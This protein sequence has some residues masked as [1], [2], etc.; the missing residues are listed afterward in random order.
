MN[1]KCKTFCFL[2]LFIFFY[3]KVFSRVFFKKLVGLLGVKPLTTRP[4][5]LTNILILTF[6]EEL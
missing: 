1:P 6:L 5:I 2:L 4:N 3:L